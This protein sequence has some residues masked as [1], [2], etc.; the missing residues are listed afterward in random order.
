MNERHP[1]QSEAASP[2]AL[3]ETRS[4]YE[5]YEHTPHEP[6]SEE[7]IPEAT[8]KESARQWLYFAR[9]F[10]NKRIVECR[11]AGNENTARE[12]ERVQ[13]SILDLFDQEVASGNPTW[14]NTFASY[15]PEPYKRGDTIPPSTIVQCGL[16]LDN[17]ALM[18]ERA[19]I[20]A[21]N[22]V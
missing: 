9:A 12:Y 8:A 14:V 17:L 1:P 6:S 18:I 4:H 22:T 21:D 2:L 5:K 7:D 20:A 13:L 16:E 3:A 10:C 19:Q 15:L 11:E